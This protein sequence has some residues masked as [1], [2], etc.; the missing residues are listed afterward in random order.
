M[1]DA[2]KPDPKPLLTQLQEA[3]T[4]MTQAAKTDAQKLLAEELADVIRRYAGELG[5]QPAAR[6]PGAGLGRS[7]LGQGRRSRAAAITSSA[8]ARLPKPCV[9]TVP[10]CSRSL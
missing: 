9:T 5:A 2:S 1:P 6:D 10:L 7:A 4:A 3:H 8:S